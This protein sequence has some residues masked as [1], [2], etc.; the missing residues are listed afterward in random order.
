MIEIEQ[1]SRT[2]LL[3]IIVASC[4]RTLSLALCDLEAATKE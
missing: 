1:S 2:I 3:S 4:Y